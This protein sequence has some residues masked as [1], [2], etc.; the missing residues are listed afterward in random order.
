MP[1]VFLKSDPVTKSSIMNPRAGVLDVLCFHPLHGFKPYVTTTLH[2]WNP[3]PLSPWQPTPY[4]HQNA[5]QSL[6]YTFHDNDRGLHKDS[7][8]K[9]RMNTLRDNT[10]IW[11]HIQYNII[12]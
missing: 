9:Y 6:W 10:S 2:P 12:N 4:C 11:I 3:I 8:Y 5:R 1:R 7:L